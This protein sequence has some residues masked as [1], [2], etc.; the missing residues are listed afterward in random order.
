MAADKDITEYNALCAVLAS[1]HEKFALRKQE[2]RPVLE[3]CAALK[4]DALLLLAKADSFTRRLT[5]GQ[6]QRIGLAYNPGEIK[7]RIVNC[8]SVVF[9]S[10]VEE[11]E[12]LP[13]IRPEFC[14]YRAETQPDRSIRRELKVKGLAIIGMIDA[15]KKRLL[16]LDLLEL[17]CRE[18]IQSIK[19]ALEAFRHELR[20]V[21][22]KIYPFGIF[23]FFSRSL[24]RLF[25]G[26][27]FSFRDLADVA[28]LGEITGLVL[29]IADTPVVQGRN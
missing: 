25:G 15:V 20:A 17:R 1:L 28:A 27:Y 23:S 29:K 4:R 21:R 5:I 26:T 10:A 9:S 3:E 12:T 19:K 13:A 24:R 7:D 2:L 8:S 11:A 16:Q 6:R 14:E 22:R 18:L